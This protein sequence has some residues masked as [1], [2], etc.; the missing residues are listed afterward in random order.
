M[1]KIF[2]EVEFSTRA[3]NSGDTKRNKLPF[4]NKYE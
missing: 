1:N 4:L 3:V 2:K